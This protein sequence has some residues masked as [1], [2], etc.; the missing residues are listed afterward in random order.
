MQ[1]ENL[2][3]AL[4]MTGSKT[5]VEASP[6]NK[7]WGI[8]L[9]ASDPHSRSRKTWKGQNLLGEILTEVKFEIFNLQSSS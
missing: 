6:F 7:I 2:R 5:L 4:L 9:H 1:N 8:G 3:K